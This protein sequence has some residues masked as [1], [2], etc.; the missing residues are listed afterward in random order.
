[1][2][3]YRSGAL[4]QSDHFPRLVDL[5]TKAHLDLSQIAKRGLSKVIVQVG[6][7]IQDACNKEQYWSQTLQP[8]QNRFKEIISNESFSRSYHQENVKMQIID[9]LESII[10]KILFYLLYY[11]F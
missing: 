9:I 4:L 8:L 6:G 10:G 5:A 7:A 3:I 1:M 2:K 11:F